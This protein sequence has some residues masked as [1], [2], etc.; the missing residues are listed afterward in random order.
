MLAGMTTHVDPQSLG[1]TPPSSRASRG[2]SAVAVLVLIGGLGLFAQGSCTTSATKP[3]TDVGSQP[4]QP[5][6]NQPDPQPDPQPQPD[7]DP[8]PT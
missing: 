2:I 1:P 7:H 4:L 8:P 6:Q 3:P 5:I